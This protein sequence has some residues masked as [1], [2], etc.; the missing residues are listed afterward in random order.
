MNKNNAVTTAIVIG[1]VVI[2]YLL[3]QQ[4]IAVPPIAKVV[5]TGLNLA[6]VTYARLS[7][8]ATV[9][10]A[11]I[12]SPIQTPGGDTATVAPVDAKSGVH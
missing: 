5:L 8:T 6:L 3:S 10:V 12:A 4:D 7:G 9:P 2:A 11:D 1:S